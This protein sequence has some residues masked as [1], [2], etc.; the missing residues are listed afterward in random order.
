MQQTLYWDAFSPRLDK[1]S[2]KVE[3]AG[4]VRWLEVASGARSWLDVDNGAI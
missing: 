3:V 1:R 4:N 2:N